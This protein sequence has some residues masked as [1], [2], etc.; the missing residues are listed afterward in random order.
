MALWELFNKILTSCKLSELCPA[1]A[2][3]LESR[4]GKFNLR[5]IQDDIWRPAIEA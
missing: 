4:N 5:S 1:N 3:L 2:E